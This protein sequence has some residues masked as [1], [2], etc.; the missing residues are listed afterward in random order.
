MSTTLLRPDDLHKI[1]EDVEMAKAREAL[2]RTKKVE[3]EHRKL[4][5]AFMADDVKPD[6]ME[7]VNV[8]VRRAAQDGKR[9]RSICDRS[10]TRRGPRS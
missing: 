2:A 3:E 1:T 10:A 9:T 5:E 8:A 7:V 6:A 4:R